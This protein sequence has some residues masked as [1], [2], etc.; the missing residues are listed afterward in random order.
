[1]LDEDLEILEDLRIARVHGPVAAVRV[2]ALAEA[3]VGNRHDFPG[4]QVVGRLPEF[5]RF[6]WGC[7]RRRLDGR[8]RIR[9]RIGRAA[10]GE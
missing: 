8:R 6:G 4:Q 9:R 7:I 5:V 2:L 1:M 10:A 3:R